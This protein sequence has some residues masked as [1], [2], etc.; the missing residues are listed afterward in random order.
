LGNTEVAVRGWSALFGF[1]SSILIY[2]IVKDFFKDRRLA[3]LIGLLPNLFVGFNALSFVFTTD[4]PLFFFWGLSFYLLYKAVE[5]DKT[6]YWVLL[7][8]SGGLGFLA[9]YSM[10]FFFPLGII[11]ILLRKP[12]LFKTVKPYLAIF[13]G[14]AF[15]I[16]VL[17]WAYKHDW[18]SFK[19]VLNLSGIEKKSRFPYWKGFF[20]FLISQ[21]VILSVGFYFYMLYGWVKNF[22]PKGKLFPLV[23]FSF[24]PYLFFQLLSLKKFVYGNWAGFAYFTGGIIAAFYFVKSFKRKWLYPFAILSVLLALFLNAITFY[25]PLIDKLHLTK[26][27][28]PKKDPTRVMIGWHDLGSLVSQNFNPKTDFIFSNLYQISSE[29]AFYTKGNPQ[30][31]VF[32]YYQRMNQFDIW[33]IKN[34]QLFEKWLSGQPI[35]PYKVFNWE[36]LKGKNGI[37]V[38]YFRN[39]PKRIMKHF[40]RKL[41]TKKVVIFW[42]GVPIQTYYIHYLVDFDGNYNPIIKGF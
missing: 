27:L 42:R 29:L 13:I 9:K 10:A 17:W 16:P 1:L 28:P 5:E 24:F 6:L 41:W 39:P 40:K 21:L 31:Y 18:V 23:L 38:T 26:L 32:N 14:F 30:T 20:N 15:T 37:F 19:H 35:P 3:F 22:Y 34:F 7:G 25:P 11:Y 36:K 2:F 33:Q 4:T 12:H 8:I